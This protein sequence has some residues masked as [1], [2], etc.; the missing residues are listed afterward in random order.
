MDG[1]PAAKL[2]PRSVLCE[3]PA[4]MTYEQLP[5]EWKEWWTSLLS[6]VSAKAS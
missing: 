6:N 4:A 1:R 5:D 3:H 2:A